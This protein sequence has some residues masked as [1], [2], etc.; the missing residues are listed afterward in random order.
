M[1]G[2]GALLGCG[3]VETAECVRSVNEKMTAIIRG[4]RSK[5]NKNK[6]TGRQHRTTRQHRER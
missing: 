5:L 1:L 2:K 3:L 4:Q 6:Q